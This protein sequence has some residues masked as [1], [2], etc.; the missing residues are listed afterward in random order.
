MWKAK[1]T[2]GLER[3]ID[4]LFELSKYFVG[5]IRHRPGWRLLLEPECTNVCFRLV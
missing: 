4:R 1:G 2:D 5:L 3:H